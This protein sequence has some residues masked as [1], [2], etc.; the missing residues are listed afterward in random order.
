M[1]PLWQASEDGEHPFDHAGSTRSVATDDTAIGK[2][3]PKATNSWMPFGQRVRRVKTFD[4]E[5]ALACVQAHRPLKPSRNPPKTS[6][7][8]FLPFLMIFK[9]ITRL[10][11]KKKPEDDQSNRNALGRKRKPVLG[12]SNVPLEITLVLS[13]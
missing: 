5:K 1:L 3:D 11:R 13:K 8:D 9:P 6:I 12:D 10:F 2:E 4:P 7:Y